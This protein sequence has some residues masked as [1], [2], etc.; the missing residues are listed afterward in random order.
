[1]LSLSEKKN[2]QST[3]G[4]NCLVWGHSY[5]LS[6][7]PLQGPDFISK[8]FDCRLG[9]IQVYNDLSCYPLPTIL[10]VVLAV[11]NK[12]NLSGGIELRK[13]WDTG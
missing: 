12:Q 6:S 5:P 7:V 13:L 3:Q 2:A 8:E 11:S 4:K 1:M 9:K 10:Y